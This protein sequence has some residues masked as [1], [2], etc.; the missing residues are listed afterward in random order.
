[1]VSGALAPSM[2]IIVFAGTLKNILLSRVRIGWLLLEDFFRMN[3]FEELL[4]SVSE[5]STGAVSYTHLSL[6]GVEHALNTV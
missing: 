2:L 3:E 5:V 4:N 6:K 1:M